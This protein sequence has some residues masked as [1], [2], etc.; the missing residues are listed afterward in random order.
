MVRVG[1][2]E[3]KEERKSKDSLQIFRQIM[4]KD[5]ELNVLGSQRVKTE[6]IVENVVGPQPP[7][8]PSTHHNLQHVVYWLN[9]LLEKFLS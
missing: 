7:H 9:V 8:H 6:R 3:E 2:E 1:K 4:D 5:K